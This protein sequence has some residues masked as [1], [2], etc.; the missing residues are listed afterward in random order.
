[1]LARLCKKMKTV[2]FFLLVWCVCV[3]LFLV[4]LV[5]VELVM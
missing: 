4:F 2:S 5:C 3:G 1:M